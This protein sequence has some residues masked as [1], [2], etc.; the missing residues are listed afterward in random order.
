MLTE[1]SQAQKD[2]YH[3]ISFNVKSKMVHL[4]KADVLIAV[5]R[6]SRE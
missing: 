3:L 1:T 4:I 2:K 5:T 6:T